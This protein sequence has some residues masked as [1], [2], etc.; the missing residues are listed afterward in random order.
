MSMKTGCE[1]EQ[2][3]LGAVKSGTINNQTAEHIKSCAACRESVKIIR[4]F[5]M[6]SMNE[7]SPEKLP[8]AGL[9]WFKSRLREKR[10]AAETVAK[11]IL[12]AQTAAAF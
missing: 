6:A 7:P 12:I 3:I 2:R 9:I 11:P 1:F 10:R 4:F 5:Q 8:V